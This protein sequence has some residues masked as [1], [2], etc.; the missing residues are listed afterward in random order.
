MALDQPIYH[1]GVINVYMAKAPG[2]ASAFDGSGTVWFK[3]AQVTAVTDGGQSINWPSLSK[4][5]MM[6]AHRNPERDIISP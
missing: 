3:V 6:V 1:P 2:A 4:L 5:I